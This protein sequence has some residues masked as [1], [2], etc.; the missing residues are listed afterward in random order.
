[1]ISFSVTKWIHLNWGDDGLIYVLLKCYSL[2]KK[3]G[4]LIIEFQ[5]YSS[6][7]KKR[8]YTDTIQKNYDRL[9]IQP[10]QIPLILQHIG[11]QVITTKIPNT[12]ATLARS[13]TKGFNR[14]I[15]V[16]KK[17]G[18]EIG[19]DFTTTTVDNLRDVFDVDSLINEVCK[20]E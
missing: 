6:Y 10:Q 3:Y 16:L 11:M 5:T 12:V 9:Q 19:I 7:Y 1:M 2:L 13:L 20:K 18:E 8:N 17:V 14:P 15:V 4:I